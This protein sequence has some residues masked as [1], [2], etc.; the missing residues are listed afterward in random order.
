MPDSLTR[1][2][3]PRDWADAFA[4]LPCEPSPAGSWQR[5]ADALPPVPTAARPS[6]WRRPAMTLAASVLLAFVVPLMSWRALHHAPPTGQGTWHIAATSPTSA[7]QAAVDAPAPTQTEAAPLAPPPSP[8]TRSTAAR[9]QDRAFPATHAT[10]PSV[11]PARLDA[12]YN[13][14]ARLEAVLA[15]LPDT[16]A[17]NVAT[18]AVAADLQDQVAHIDLALSQSALPIDTRAA[19]WEE[20]V[21]TLRQLTGVETTQRWSVAYHDSAPAPDTAIY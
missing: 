7:S 20:R 11:Q 18:L 17:S 10:T 3:M 1:E 4:A 13:E 12:L 6:R 19:L 5:L 15:Q 9:V 8:D 2:P 14:S 16:G 21:D